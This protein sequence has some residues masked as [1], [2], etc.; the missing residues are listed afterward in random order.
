MSQ[1]KEPD[2][3]LNPY[4]DD[5][6][7]GY[8]RGEVKAAR[9]VEGE[10]KQVKVASV[11]L[12]RK[13]DL[14]APMETQLLMGE[15][16]R[17][18]EE[19]NGWAWGQSAQDD[20]VGY[21]DIKALT[22]RPCKPTHYVAAIRTFL[23]A[24]ADLK[25]RPAKPLPMNAK[26]QIVTTR[27]DFSEAGS[28]GWVF[29]AHLE[30]IGTYERDFVAVAERLV[31]TPYLWGG[32]DTTGLDCSG[33]VQC[34][35][36]RAGISSLRDTDMQEATLGDPLAP[37]L[38]KATLMRGDLVFWKGHVG[39]MCDDTRLVHASGYHMRVEIEPLREA[40]ERIASV[41]GPVTSIKRL[42]RR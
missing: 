5:L 33:L 20:Y 30:Y 13:P 31:G 25:S 41:A 24:R 18:Y 9:F 14:N 39:I 35:L 17:V 1:A 12:M 37:P 23:Y 40:V 28:G 27:G 36:E 15:N 6:A 7:A 2:R 22:D 19:R 11:P 16:F 42:N 34:A 10:D 38:D 32:R 29:T 8:L 3:R 4:R 21:V 26:L